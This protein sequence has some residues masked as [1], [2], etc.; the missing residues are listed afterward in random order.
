MNFSEPIEFREAVRLLAAKKLMPTNLTSAELAQLN[1]QILRTS[2][3]SAQTTLEGLLERYKTG[4]GNLINP[5]LEPGVDFNPARLRAFIKEYL[6]SIS[7][8]PN[9]GEEGSIKDLS[10]DGR[11]N[12]VIKTNVELAQGAGKFVQGNS[13]EDVIDLWPAQEL[14]RYEERDKPRDWEKRWELAAQ[15]ANDPGAVR[16]S[17]DEGRM[18]ALKSSGIWQALGDGA[19]GYLDTLGNPF[20]PFAFNSGMWTDD[21]SR[22]EA[23]EL[24]LLE[25]GEKAEG[26]DFDLSSLFKAA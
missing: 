22:K 13:N 20:P 7:Y 23:E 25:E 24:G 12:L 5:T 1:K 2:F 11:I 18:V 19:G 14:V 8:A 17:S 21:V 10:S 15:V 3:T 9:E 6:T 26:A 4:V 16:V